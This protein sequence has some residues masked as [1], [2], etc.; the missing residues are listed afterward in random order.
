MSS[1]YMSA[2]YKENK[3]KEKRKEIS[4]RDNIYRFFPV[5]NRIQIWLKT[6]FPK[7]Q[8]RSES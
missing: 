8:S 3:K 7:M 4:F 6:S 2:L 5:H 1:V